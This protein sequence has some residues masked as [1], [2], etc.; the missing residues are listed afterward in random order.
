MLDARRS[1]VQRYIQN[2]SAN[3]V[4]QRAQ[5]MDADYSGKIFFSL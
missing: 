4:L 1:G 2:I 3:D 5:D